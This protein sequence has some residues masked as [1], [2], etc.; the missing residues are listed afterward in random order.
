MA[1]YQNNFSLTAGH[2]HPDSERDFAP[3]RAHRAHG[4][5]AL[6]RVFIYRDT[7]HDATPDIASKRR[8]RCRY[9][10]WKFARSKRI[11]TPNIE[12]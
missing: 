2:P 5:A 11:G 10:E 8:T 7:R 12:S 4:L 3:A 9:P 6:K 1:A